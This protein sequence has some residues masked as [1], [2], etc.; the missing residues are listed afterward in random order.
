MYVACSKNEI[1]GFL[2]ERI[3]VLGPCSQF[4]KVNKK[5]VIGVQYSLGDT[6]NQRVLNNLQRTRLPLRRMIWLLSL[7]P[8]SPPGPLSV[9]SIG[10][11]QLDTNE[12]YKFVVFRTCYYKADYFR[13]HHLVSH[14]NFPFCRIFTFLP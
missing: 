12:K 10:D 9:S 8:P 1:S 2:V 13:S 7:F 11:S 4:I 3:P 14:N 6:F 5:N